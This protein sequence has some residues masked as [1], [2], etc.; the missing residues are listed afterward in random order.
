MAKANTFVV[1]GKT[2]KA[3]PI[4]FNAMCA[5][6]E[7]GVSVENMDKK[8]LSTAR[9]Y[10]CLCYDGGEDAVAAGKEIEEHIVNGGK[11]D[12]LMDAM[13]VEVDK[14]GF[15]RAVSQ[16]KTKATGTVS[17]EKAEAEK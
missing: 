10:F 4:D 13:N 5:L 14:S 9:A 15:F 11:L 6:E 1:N 12:D 7:V 16:N 17:E 2:Y 3:V 8:P